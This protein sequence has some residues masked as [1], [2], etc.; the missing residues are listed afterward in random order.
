MPTP[1]NSESRLTAVFE[2]AVDGILIIDARGLIQTVN[3]AVERM[4]GW[5][6]DELTGKNVKMLMPAPYREEHD[7]YLHRYLTTGEK[8]IIGIGRE[9]VAQRRDGSTLPIWLSVAEIHEDGQRLFAGIV[10]DI[11]DLKAAQAAR[12]Q[13]IA[14]LEVKNAELERFTYTVSHDLK[15]PLITIKGFVGQLERSVEAGKM[16]RFR[17]DVARIAAAADKLRTLLDDVLELSR[18]GRVVRPPEDVGL[19]AVVT[20]TLEL[21]DAPIRNRGAQISVAAGMPV[22]RADRTRLREIVQNLVENALKFSAD[23]PRIEIGARVEGRF[24]VCHVRDHGLGVEARYI[25][26]I[27]GLFEQ[28]DRDASGTGIGLALV[29]R[30]VEV[31]GGRAWGESEGPGTGTTMYFTL[32]LATLA[33]SEPTP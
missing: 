16:D 33:P 20:E 9:V 2:A 21:L 15:S 12:E 27:F 11:S 18:I 10:R 4:F 22:V 25:D 17:A 8:R 29:R 6:A 32:P 13:L 24:A 28:L 26:R 31:H 5:P 1:A 14:E 19:D 3:P 7:G 23:T 30:I